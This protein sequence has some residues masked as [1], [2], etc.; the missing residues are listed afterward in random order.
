LEVELRSGI[1]LFKI[2]IEYAGASE[3]CMAIYNG[4]EVK[5]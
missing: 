4:A 3:K 1:A 5:L 2:V